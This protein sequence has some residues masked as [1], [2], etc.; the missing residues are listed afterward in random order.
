MYV[1]Y[2][3]DGKLFL[4]RTDRRQW[5]GLRGVELIPTG[6]DT[7]ALEFVG[8][9]YRFARDTAGRVIALFRLAPDGRAELRMARTNF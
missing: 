6:K 4:K 5:M 3:A 8:S 2:V 7:F 1:V 9:S